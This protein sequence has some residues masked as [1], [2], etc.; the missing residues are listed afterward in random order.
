MNEKEFYNKK[1]L[2]ITKIKDVLILPDI[3]SEKKNSLTT[4]L[5]IVEK[6]TYRNRLNSKGAI[7]HIIIDN[8]NLRYSF[9]EE[10]ILFDK[11]TN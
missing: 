5:K 6:Y 3:T 1:E 4:L 8:L 9:C 10:F 2:L 11:S 7:S